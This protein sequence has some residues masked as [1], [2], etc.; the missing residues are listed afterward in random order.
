M[1]H[2]RCI[3]SDGRSLM[4]LDT[5]S[6]YIISLGTIGR[7]TRMTI[8]ADSSASDYE[9]GIWKMR[10]IATARLN[11]RLVTPPR[12]A[13]VSLPSIYIVCVRKN[14][15]IAGRLSSSFVS[16]VT[17]DLCAME[18]GCHSANTS[19]VEI[20]GNPANDNLGIR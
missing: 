7:L 14:P 5:D 13:E 11:P 4:R 10:L 6:T 3:L 9:A 8:H 2:V 19:L 15:V 20:Q 16:R 17:G 18:F 12:G 1:V